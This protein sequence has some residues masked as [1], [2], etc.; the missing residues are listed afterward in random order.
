MQLIIC[1]VKSF[2]WHKVTP[3]HLHTIQCSFCTTEAEVSCWDRDC[4]AQ[5]D[6]R[7]FTIWSFK[8]QFALPAV[9]N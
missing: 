9:D 6:L 7:I 1:F 4:M 2:Y 3:T 5:K 8:K